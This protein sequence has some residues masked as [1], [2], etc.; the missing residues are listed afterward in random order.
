MSTLDV[1]KKI[2]DFRKIALDEM[3]RRVGFSGY[4][5]AFTEQDKWYTL[6]EWTLEE[7]RS[8]MEWMIDSYSKTFREPKYKSKEA[9]RMFNL[10]YGWKVK[11]QL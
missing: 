4:D 2:E 7:E 3:F 5:P 9:V 11:G 1:K 8:F 10:Q 6:R